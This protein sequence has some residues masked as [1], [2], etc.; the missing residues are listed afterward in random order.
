[1]KL[2]LDGNAGLAILVVA[3]A[4][5]ALILIGCRQSLRRKS[6]S[7]RL[8]LIGLRSLSFVLLALTLAG[9][10]VQYET[11]AP[12]RIGM[13]SLTTRAR[14]ENDL[15]YKR[16]T[17]A[18]IRSL[19]A[20]NI[21]T[22]T[23]EPAG[24]ASTNAPP[25][26]LDAEI[27]MT[28]GDIDATSAQNELRRVS[29][30][31]GAPVFIVTNQTENGRP[32]VALESV[33]IPGLPR[34]G[35]PLLIQC[36]VRA[37]QMQGRAS[38]LTI[39]DGAKV[40][41]STS[42]RWSGDNEWQTVALEVVPKVAGWNDYVAHIEA[43][44][45]GES[46]LLSR[47]FTLQA[48]EQRIR[49]LFVEGEPTWEAKFIRR[50][51]EQSD[52][53]AI[54]YFAQVSRV[55]AAG[56]ISSGEGKDPASGDDAGAPR[57]N[58]RPEA[59]L[60]SV[61]RNG[62]NDYD[63]LIAGPMSG[64]TL[65]ALEAANVRDWVERRGG[66][67]IV[68]GGNSFAGS[69]AAP[70]GRLYDL[71]PAAASPLGFSHET[72]PSIPTSQ[73]INAN[74]ERKYGRIHLTPT[75]SA[76]NGVLRAYWEANRSAGGNSL[77]QL[78]GEGFRL[79]ALRPG[80]KVLAVS[81]D[82]EANTAEES[83]PPL[84]AAMRYGAGQVVVFAPADSW[85]MRTSSGDASSDAIRPFDALWQGLALWASSNA[86]P[87]AEISLSDESPAV[88]QHVTV[89]IH[90]RDDRFRSVPLAKVDARL[91]RL[92]DASAEASIAAASVPGHSANVSHQDGSA[93][94]ASQSQEIGFVP[95]AADAGVWRASFAAPAAGRYRLTVDYSSNG[96]NSKGMSGT[97]S[98]EF[99]T[100]ESSLSSIVS[101]DTLQ[102]LARET[103]G[104]FY[105]ASN[106][107]LLT[108]RLASLH[109]SRGTVTKTLHLRTWWPLAFILPLLL[110]GEWLLRR[111][112]IED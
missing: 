17:A 30:T 49:V 12:L 22:I 8:L 54:D 41:A 51:L 11:A 18:L 68:L 29:A 67:L 28:D 102:R 38:L 6:R 78:S 100:V 32:Y 20:K 47:S 21:E 90:V 36:R 27:L 52:L 75:Q 76:A 84:I 64:A 59:K 79:A 93:P 88:H 85:R 58:L 111:L 48:T 1:M 16:E 44:D 66:G 33:T 83:G 37:R 94:I 62:L 99:G 9:L 80:A 7:I 56:E 63:L 46:E 108:Q 35:V 24:I 65:S 97:L 96:A 40:Q 3:L 2:L 50:S 61:L 107:E 34:R 104:D 69:I 45:A 103:G 87:A 10:R 95:A 19:K 15:T 92:P 13:R 42:V 23:I 4:L 110:S 91:Q 106:P 77:N 53:F 73:E 57:I 70:N 109:Q 81:S 31:G 14:S 39:S 101:Q 89:E 86:K 71:M 60:H 112:L 98:K 26:S 82:R 5:S 25:E 55:A 105:S 43:P 74:K 72:N